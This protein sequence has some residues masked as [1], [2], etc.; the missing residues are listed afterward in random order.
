MQNIILPVR[1][2]VLT[3]AA[4]PLMMEAASSSETSVN[5]YQTTRRTNPEDSLPDIF[6]FF[7]PPWF[8]VNNVPTPW[9][10]PE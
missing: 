1:F 2:R 4:I 7:C 5:P 8:R 3:A 9:P 6:L 10:S